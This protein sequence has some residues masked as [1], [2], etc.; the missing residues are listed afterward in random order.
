VEEFFKEEARESAGFVTEY[1]M[2][3]KKIVEY[4]AKAELLERRKIND[5]GFGALG[6]VAAGYIGRN[7]LAIGDDAIDNPAGD[8]LLDGAEMIGKGVAGG[9]AGLGHQ[10]G[11]VYAGGFGLGDGAGD[12]RDQ[13]IRKNAGVERARPKEDQVGLL[14]GFDGSGERAHAARGKFEFLDRRAAAGGDA[15]FAVNGTAIFERSNK[16]YVRKCGREDAAANGENFTADANGL[17][18]IAG[19]VRERRKEKI[20]EIVADEAAA[21]LKAKLEQ[22][23]KQRFVFRKSHHAVAN[24]AGRKDAVLAAQAAGAA[25]VVGHGNDGSEIGDRT[26]GAGVFVAAADDQFLE[27]AEE[28]GEAC[29]A[30]KSN[31]A[32]AVSESPRF[33]GA[34]LHDGI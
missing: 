16:V 2:F 22:P 6:A 25:T 21:G 7:G 32:E 11:D 13:Q 18:E 19:N 34:F 28:R 3:F 4:D 26:F 31:D 9:F 14:D 5:H 23:A 10:I 15:G 27:A 24:V 17:G 1:G 12:L 29:A 33:G 20:A 30:A 8:M